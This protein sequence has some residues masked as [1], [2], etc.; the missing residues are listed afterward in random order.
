MPE[1]R[2]IFFENDIIMFTETWGNQLT[3]FYV[4]NFQYFEL[5]R[6]G[7]KSGTKRSSGGL[8]VYIRDSILKPNSKVVLLK[9]NDDVIWIALDDINNSPDALYLC[10]C[11]NL[12]TGTSRQ[13]LI[14]DNLFDRLSTYMV[15]LQSLT[16][17]TCKFIICGDLNARTSDMK[18]FVSDDT[19]RHVY[20]LP[21][22]Y[23]VD[24]NLFRISQDTATNAHGL[25]L[26]DFCKQ[27][28][29][30]IAN[31]RVGSDARVGKCTY[32]GSGGSS[33][34]DYVLVSEDL[35][36]KFNTFYVH[37][38]NALTDH[39][40]I[41]FSMNILCSQYTD[42]FDTQPVCDKVEN[43]YKWND[44]SRSDYKNKIA[45]EE[46]RNKLSNIF[47]NLDGS[48]SLSSIDLCLDSFVSV[49]DDVCKP[50][51]EKTCINSNT[52][53]STFVY[54]EHC[55]IKKLDFFDKLNK[56]R[57]DK[58]D[59]NRIAMVKARSVFKTSVKNFKDQLQKQ[60][61]AKLIQTRFKESKEYWRLLKESQHNKTS[62]SLSAK[63]FGD[64][65]KAIN[66]PESN[67]YQAD[68]DII[69]FNNRFFKH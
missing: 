53:K 9:E 28:G 22:D 12:P 23:V 34:I 4:E 2:E 65:F 29:L 59:E 33:L 55:E 67:F 61:T 44:A 60:K 25:C 14:E 17:K 21:E 37:D 64:Y 35:L 1:I 49:I 26:I 20:A 51:F 50:L 63:A 42:G 32:V 38:P 66:D 68:D 47:E 52:N 46:I 3:N 48:C 31:G 5:N 43:K 54:S 18:D 16:D 11:Y 8:V 40:V 36:H 6:T 30:R 7:Y 58:S 69:D 57:K 39:C 15:H 27:S 24:N 10:L 13:A 19:S 56:Y 45:S 62:K 41:E